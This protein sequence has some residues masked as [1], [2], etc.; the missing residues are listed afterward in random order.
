MNKRQ[1]KKRYKKIHGCNP[2][3]TAP[4]KWRQETQKNMKLY[5]FDTEALQM[6]VDELRKAFREAG[7]ADTEALQMAVD[8]LRKAF[9]EA[10]LK[11][12]IILLV[13]IILYFKN[14]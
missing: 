2:P 14:E 6:A 13:S 10:K 12:E 7:E 1:A 3:K 5:D 11:I 4:E 8:E 9:R